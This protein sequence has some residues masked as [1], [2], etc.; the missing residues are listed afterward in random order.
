MISEEDSFHT[1]EYPE[2]F[3]I[4][5][6]INN[7]STSSKRIKDGKKVAEGFSYTSQNNTE[8]MSAEDLKIWIANN[9]RLLNAIS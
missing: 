7:W 8:W 5:P 3:K 1:F 2:H 4:L 9:Y 6:S